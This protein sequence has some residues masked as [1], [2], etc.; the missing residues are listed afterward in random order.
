MTDDFGILISVVIP[1]CFFFVGV[2]SRRDGP[3]DVSKE[4]L[5]RRIYEEE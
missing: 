3:R 2:V 4:E 1:L 5:L